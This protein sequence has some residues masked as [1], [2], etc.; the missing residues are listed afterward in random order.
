VWFRAV[1]SFVPRLKQ[2]GVAGV[3]RDTLLHIMFRYRNDNGPPSLVEAG[4]GCTP[5]QKKT[6]GATKHMNGKILVIMCYFS[7]T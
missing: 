5:D 2:L 7:P 3:S 4:L 1:C 6:S